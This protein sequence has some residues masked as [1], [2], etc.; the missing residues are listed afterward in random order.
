MHHEHVL[1]GETKICFRKSVLQKKREKESNLATYHTL[2]LCYYSTENTAQDK[3]L[4]H[5]LKL[6][7]YVTDSSGKELGMTKLSMV[8]AAMCDVLRLR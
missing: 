1:T 2:F 6:K 7:H 4:Y 5:W 3:F 8:Q